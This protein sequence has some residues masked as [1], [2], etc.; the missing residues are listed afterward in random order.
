MIFTAGKRY[1]LKA[2]RILEKIL[3]LLPFFQS[4]RTAFKRDIIR[5]IR[6]LLLSTDARQCV[7]QTQ[8]LFLNTGAAP[9]RGRLG[10]ANPGL[11]VS[12]ITSP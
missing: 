7:K 10:H 3:P 5:V 4:V 11:S 2:V 6:I 9:Y 8:A 1:P 12:R